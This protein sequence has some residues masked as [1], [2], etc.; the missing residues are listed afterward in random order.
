MFKIIYLLPRLILNLLCP[1][2]NYYHNLLTDLCVS[3]TSSLICFIFC[4]QV[5]LHKNV[6]LF[7]SKTYGF[8]VQ[9]S[10]PSECLEYA[11]STTHVIL[12][13]YPLVI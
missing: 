13:S 7:S 10:Y 1:R 4:L 3:V 6:M 12:N 11:I 2:V 9:L 8:K 5:N